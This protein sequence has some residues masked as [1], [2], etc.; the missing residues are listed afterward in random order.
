MPDFIDLS[1]LAPWRQVRPTAADRAGFDAAVDAGG[2]HPGLRVFC[3]G[4]GRLGIDFRRQSKG[5][6]QQL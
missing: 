5:R 4:G 6:T 3:A 2:D 1:P